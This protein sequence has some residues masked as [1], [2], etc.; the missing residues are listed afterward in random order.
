MLGSRWPAARRGLVGLAA[1]VALSVGLPTAGGASALPGVRAYEM[2][3]PPDKSGGDVMAAWGRTR[4]AADGTAVGFASLAGFGDAMGSGVSVDYLSQRSAAGSPGDN[5]WH[6]HAITPAQDA[7]GT[8]AV[9]GGFDSLYIGAFS[10]DLNRG[11]FF[12]GRPVT[13]SPSVRDV[14]NFYRR[15]D[16]RTPGAGTYDLLTACP[17]CDVSGTPLPPLPNFPIFLV[18]VAPALAGATPN[19][20]HVVF[21]S[22]YNLTEDAPAQPPSCVVT[23]DFF[24]ACRLRLYEWDRGTV[25]LAGVLPDGS[26]ADVSFAGLGARRPSLTPHVV[27]DGSDGHIRIF[28]TQPTDAT[29]LTSN[30]VP[31]GRQ[32]AINNATSGKLFMRVDGTTTV[33]LNDSERGS[34]DAFAP[35]RYL[36]AGADGRH[37]VFMTAQA[38]TD[39]APTDGQSKI[40]LYDATKPASAPDNLTLLNADHELGDGSDAAGVIGISRDGRY[41]YMIVTGQIV[42]GGPLNGTHIFLWHDDKVSEVGPMPVTTVLEENLSATPAWRLNWKESRVT[43]DG[44]H[45]LFGTISGE[46]LTGYDHGSCDTNIGLGCR[47]LYVYSADTDQLACASCVPSGAPA[48][49][50]ASDVDYVNS[51]ASTINWNENRALS[52]DGSRAFFNTAEALVPEDTNGRVDAYEYDVR[53]RT[54][55]LLSSGK[56]P[57]GSWFMDASADGGDA[58]FVTREHLVGWDRDSAYDLYDARMGGGFPEP[59]PAPPACGGG[60]CQGLPGT[61]PGGPPTAS[62]SYE[63]PGDARPRLQARKSRKCRKGHVKVRTR[64]KSKCVK[65]KRARRR[66]RRAHRPERSGS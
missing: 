19:L 47:E 35:A 1:C 54:V 62:D 18:R 61:A 43:P 20:D 16:L 56:S 13:T 66:A 7:N 28:F 31:V 6:T 8:K 9:A 23:A 60:T 45:L 39:D 25:R 40:Y 17:A 34:R 3:S 51:G 37:I 21:E 58:F 24:G 65:A 14:G 12:A 29:G 38:L 44:R 15:S 36:D 52:D 42:S 55:A 53:S 5:G 22:I 46:G 2:V 26:P 32:T 4:S 27:S 41:V 11:V 64:D 50:M 10:T 63:G 33:Q 48:T 59:T 30:E 49:Q 57:T